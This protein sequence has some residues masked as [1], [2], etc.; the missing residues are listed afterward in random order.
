MFAGL[1]STTFFYIPF[2]PDNLC[3]LVCAAYYFPI[4]RW[5][6]TF[7]SLIF[8]SVGCFFVTCPSRRISDEEE[9]VYFGRCISGYIAYMFMLTLGIHRV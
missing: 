5:V 7:F 4:L 6:S 9:R 3:L 1:P 8:F 2:S